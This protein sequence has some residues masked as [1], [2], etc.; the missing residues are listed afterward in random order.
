[1]G[2]GWYDHDCLNIPELDLLRRHRLREGA[3]VFD[4]GAHQCVV[5]LMMSQIVGSTGQVIALEPNYHNAAVA[6]RNRELNDAGNL[7]IVQAAAA[8]RSG[9]LIFN[10][11]LDGNVDDGSGEWGQCEVP[12][13][14]V[15][16]LAARYGIPDVLFIDVEGFEENVLKGAAHT[17][18]HRPDCFV[19]VHVG[20]G[21]ERYGSSARSV[22]NFF[23][24]HDYR[25][26][27]AAQSEPSF[28]L[29]EP[30]APVPDERFFIVAVSESPED[31]RQ[32]LNDFPQSR[33]EGARSKSCAS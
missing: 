4:L 3:R 5:A 13:L 11:G 28:H 10:L 12:C 15:D 18:G 25:L 1:M 21:L 27:V 26:F 19:E 16:D 24:A 14:S 17:L 2:E 20:C 29:L 8:D 22:V 9:T 32:S 33:A 23:P 7:E 31:C 6:R 30:N